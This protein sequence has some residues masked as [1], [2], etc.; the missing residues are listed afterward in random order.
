[1]VYIIIIIAVAV[2]IFFIACSG[3]NKT[4][5]ISPK[6]III[7]NDIS[8]VLFGDTIKPVYSKSQIELKL[9]NLAETPPPKELAFGAMC[10]SPAL[11]EETSYEY[12]CPECGEKTIYKNVFTESNYYVEENDI[13]SA[14][15]AVKAIKGLNIKLD[16]SQFCSHCRST[17]VERPTLC[18]LVNIAGESDTTKVCGVT[19]HDLILLNDFLNEKPTYFDDYDYEHALVD[20]QYRIEEMLGIKAKK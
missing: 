4:E 2:G 11:I 7:K 3:D 13:A 1:M 5:E 6:S 16:E 8:V 19:Y 17:E 9:K 18:L 15:R 12:I 20:E 10:Y 14:R